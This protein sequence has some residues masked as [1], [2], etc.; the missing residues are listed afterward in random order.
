MKRLSS[1]TMERSYSGSSWEVIGASVQGPYHKNKGQPNQDAIGWEQKKP[2]KLPIILSVADGLGDEMFFRSDR[3]SRFA[4]EASI[5]ICNRHIRKIHRWREGQLRHRL[6]DEIIECWNQKIFEDLKSDPFSPEEEQ[7]ST[8]YVQHYFSKIPEVEGI[9]QS[10]FIRAY[11]YSTTLNTVIV[12][13][14]AIIALQVGDGD[15]VIVRD[16]GSTK[17]IFS[18]KM[19]CGRV[20]PLSYPNVRDSCN[21]CRRDMRRVRPL[22]IYLS[23]DGYSAGYD[24]SKV[25]F[26]EIIAFEFHSKIQEFSVEDIHEALPSLLEELSQGSLDDLTLGII[27]GSQEKIRKT[28][29]KLKKLCDQSEEV[30]EPGSVEQ[31]VES[32]PVNPDANICEPEEKCQP[33]DD[34]TGK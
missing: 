17:E 18:L 23:T 34:I 7:L 19:D 9:D 27:V 2:G 11:P 30:K 14:T 28:Q 1:D 20:I 15:I 16:D 6:L 3:G 31:V 24:S 21:I 13:S 8:K 32:T 29:L 5:E 10:I 4:I 12:T 33:S 25:D 22:I 26:D